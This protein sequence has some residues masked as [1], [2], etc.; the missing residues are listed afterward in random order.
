MTD[1][2]D[3]TTSLL[4]ERSAEA[5]SFYELGASSP[6]PFP[7]PP[8]AYPSA[9][10]AAYPAA[11]NPISP[12]AGIPALPKNVPAMP[13]YQ[14]QPNY[15]FLPNGFVQ[16][17]ISQQRKKKK[18]GGFRRFMSWLIV[19][20]V[21][22]GGVYAGV[23]FGP[24]L[25]ASAQGNPG[26]E[27]G[28]TKA[29][30]VVVP[31]ATAPRTVTVAVE[32]P[33]DDNS[34]IKYEVA[35]DLQTGV[36][37]MV[38]DRVTQPDIEV[39]AVFDVANL[40]AVDSP[41][42]YSMPRGDFPVPAGAEQQEWLRTVDQYLPDSIRPYV[43]IDSATEAVLGTE[44]MRHLVVTVDAA[45]VAAATART[46]TDPATGL[47]VPAFA[48]APGQFALPANVTGSTDA[49]K[50]VKVEMWVDSSGTIRKLIEP[51]ALGGK[52]YTV[53]STSP[54]AYTP[55]FPAPESTTPL[56]ASQLLT[57]SL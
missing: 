26:N 47:Q 33:G 37:R 29:F 11:G 43:T 42:W 51:A 16:E 10:P 23:R 38:I 56:T 53:L 19:L 48:S 22:G 45:A 27:P 44:T 3:P 24:H 49:I 40:R 12:V 57:F 28:A 54:D 50:P 52:T 35:N 55:T 20:A 30:P 5:R 14:P 4:D 39:L 34:T 36:T 17:P 9:S 32:Q 1:I 2:A 21:V 46:V 6:T 25:L 7:P 31:Q 13:S 15:Q 18:S 8:P 41:Q